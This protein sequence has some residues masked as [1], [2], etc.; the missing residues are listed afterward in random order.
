MKATTMAMV[1]I[2]V[3][4]STTWLIYAFRVVD[5]RCQPTG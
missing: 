3:V 1:T 5:P 4:N 2:R